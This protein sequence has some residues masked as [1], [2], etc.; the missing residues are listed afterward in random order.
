MWSHGSCACDHTHTLG[1]AGGPQNLLD[2][3]LQG[4]R[5]VAVAM[6]PAVGVARLAAT[7][8]PIQTGNG[9]EVRR[10]DDSP[11][12]A[13]DLS[14]LP[15]HYALRLHRTL[16]LGRVAVVHD[17]VRDPARVA[18][19]DEERN[20]ALAA[21]LEHDDTLLVGLDPECVEDQRER[22]LLRAPFDEE[23]RTREEQFRAVAVELG[24]GPELSASASGSG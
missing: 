5:H 3:A 2:R 6:E 11:R 9:L 14:D 20:V 12:A 17:D 13:G 23:R 10:E 18:D 19:A 24:Q 4:L 15:V 8:A 16:S 7:A 1:G 22:Q 21:T